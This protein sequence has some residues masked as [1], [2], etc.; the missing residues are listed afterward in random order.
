MKISL[1]N[2]FRQGKLVNINGF[3]FHHI[4]VQDSC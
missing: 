4:S 1:E 3:E 2:V